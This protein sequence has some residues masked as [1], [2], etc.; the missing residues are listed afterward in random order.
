VGA[1]QEQVQQQLE[2]VEPEDVE[3]A[4][5]NVSSAAWLTLLGLGAS[6]LA[7]LVGG[8]LGRRREA[9]VLVDTRTRRTAR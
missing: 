6:A 7:A 2:N 9:D 1:V 3:A 5:R 4:A 8:M